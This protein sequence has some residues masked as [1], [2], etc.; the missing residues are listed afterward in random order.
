MQALNLFIQASPKSLEKA[1]AQLQQAKAALEAINSTQANL[2]GTDAPCIYPDLCL[3]YMTAP[4]PIVQPLSTDSA[5][6]VMRASVDC[7]LEACSLRSVAD[8]RAVMLLAEHV[9]VSCDLA[10]M[11]GAIYL[12]ILPPL[13]ADEDELP[14]WSPTPRR[15]AQ[16][17][18]LPFSLTSQVLSA[19]F[20]MPEPE[21]RSEPRRAPP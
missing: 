8:F 10:L 16:Q 15:F 14:D 17:L 2:A 20:L 4:T 7:L 6:A 5:R 11:R 9:L 21:A 13:V 12:L 3:M 18:H 1:R 19:E